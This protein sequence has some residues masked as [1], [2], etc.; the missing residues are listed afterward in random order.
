MVNPECLASLLFV[1]VMRDGEAVIITGTE[2][3]SKYSGYSYDFSYDGPLKDPTP[4][5]A[6]TQ[7]L[8]TVIIAIDA[9]HYKHREMQYHPDALGRELLKAYTGFSVQGDWYTGSLESIS[10]GS[11]D[12][13]SHGRA[14]FGQRTIATGNWGCGAFGGDVGI[15]SMLQW[16]AAT[17][18][19][20]DIRY[21]TFRDPACAP[22]AEVVRQL[23]EARV[24]VAALWQALLAFPGG[25][26]VEERFQEPD[27]P[28][29]GDEEV[30]PCVLPGDEE[31]VSQDGM[32]SND[33]TT[34]HGGKWSVRLVRRSAFEYVLAMLAPLASSGADTHEH[35]M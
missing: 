32:D 11:S 35:G 23:T 12:E 19:G 14:P 31:V 25:A 22:L 28:P 5:D 1:E 30:G 33:T 29:S 18:S 7:R 3:F 8:Q 9:T 34:G 13:Q 6:E 2:R 10:P 26:L 15:K 21:F 16:I 24:T 4:L 27:S 20:K 17:L